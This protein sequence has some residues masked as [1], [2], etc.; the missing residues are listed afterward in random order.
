MEMYI[1]EIAF[2]EVASYAHFSITQGV[3][4]FKYTLLLVL[5]FS[6]CTHYNTLLCSKPKTHKFKHKKPYA[7]KS[8]TRD[9]A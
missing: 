6:Y 8:L 1:K 5:H 7:Y 4:S 9:N 2:E 3:D